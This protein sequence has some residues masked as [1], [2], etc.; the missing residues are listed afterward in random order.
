VPDY[1]GI[2]RSRAADY[3]CLVAREDYRGNIL[4]ALQEIRPLQG[5]DVVELG[6]GTGRLTRLLAPMVNRIRLLDIS[7]HMLQTA[8][9]SL[10]RA[11]FQNWSASVADNR[12]LPLRAGTAD[13][14]LA[15]WTLGH[16]LSWYPDCWQAE[17]GRALAEMKRVLGPGGNIIILETLGTG[18]EVPRPPTRGLAS[19]YNWLE[20]YHGFSASWIR[21]D[22]RFES[23]SEASRLLRFFFGQE[24]AEPLVRAG[25]PIVPECTG[26]WHLTV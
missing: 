21:T 14:T 19:Y 3:D 23:Q 6:A 2:Y 12:A 26:I 18:M 25:N 9:A 13:T 11:G 15:G 8:Q 10:K 24:V 7:S 20:Q 16:F 5:L 1:R 17:I 22:Y 4:P